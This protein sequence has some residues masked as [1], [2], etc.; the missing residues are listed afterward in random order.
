MKNLTH[1]DLMAHLEI[2]VDL[3]G[4]NDGTFELTPAEIA[5]LPKAQAVPF[6]TKSQAA[7]SQWLVDIGTKNA[8]SKQEQEEIA[9]VSKQFEKLEKS[10]SYNAS[11][12][13][14]V[15]DTRHAMPYNPIMSLPV[16]NARL[17]F[18]ANTVYTLN[19]PDDCIVAQIVATD[20]VLV[21]A[22][23]IPTDTVSGFQGIVGDILIQPG[24]T[25]GL[26]YIKGVRQ[27]SV[28]SLGG[29][30]TLIV[31]GWSNLI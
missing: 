27:L 13:D 24:V 9:T 10:D 18:A 15:Q 8:I 31:H 14:V 11:I 3:G 5:N 4:G 23:N 2:P 19:L 7:Q 1:F 21:S 28:R 17:D 26:W 22:S 20:Y 12:H 30:G 6:D 16:S 29:T 25:L